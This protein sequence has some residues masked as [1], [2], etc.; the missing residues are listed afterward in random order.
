MAYRPNLGYNE[1]VVAKRKT[2]LNEKTVEILESIAKIGTIMFLGIAAPGAA[3][4]IIKLLGWAPDYRSN[5]R[6]KRAIKSLENRKFVRFW[7]KN[8]KGH[9]ALTE[10]G[11]NYFANLQAKK[12]K[13]P[14]NPVWDGK[15][16]IV[17]FDIPEKQKIQRK[18]FSNTL[19][20]IGMCNLEKSI[21]VY[22]HECKDAVSKIASLYGVEGNIKY[23]V[24]DSIEPDRKLKMAFPFTNY[25]T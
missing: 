6:T 17:T 16:R 12:I 20:F 15:W 23:I 10:E 24:A 1:W 8:G 11:K 14:H 4:H 5:Y 7:I 22:P 18:R 9:L 19:T 21:F 2:I 13:L 3:G 25:K